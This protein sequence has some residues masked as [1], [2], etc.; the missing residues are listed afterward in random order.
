MSA[1]H[2]TFVWYEL[3]T[4]DLPAARTFYAQLLGWRLEPLPAGGYA[5]IHAGATPIGG[6]MVPSAPW[7]AQGAQR[8]W[9]GY[10][11]VDDLGQAV[12]R[13]QALGGIV[14]RPATRAG[15]S[16]HFAVV[17]DP[18]GA[19][20]HLF[21]SARPPVPDFSMTP[22][23]VA[24]RELRSADWQR[25]FGFYHVLF[26]WERGEQLKAQAGHY[27]VFR[28]A[29]TAAGGMVDITGPPAGGWQYYFAVG[30]IDAAAARLTGGGG[31]VVEG[32]HEL[33]GGMWVLEATDPQGAV[34]ALLGP[35]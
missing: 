26:G 5:V 9:L 3:V 6:I 14:Q 18:L 22:G 20:L 28:T 11:E 31:H 34:F 15:D 29:G 32:P 19:V 30:N 27:Q 17:A 23:R 24:W 21:Q 13:V 10:V 16:G 33:Q 1:T 12:A 8:G 35:R 2:G 7:H 4:T 25:C